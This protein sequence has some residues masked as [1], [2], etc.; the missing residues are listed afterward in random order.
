MARPKSPILG[1]PSAVSQTLPGFR[2]R[3]TRP[4][5]WAKA[6][7]LVIPI[8]SSST[9]ADRQLALGGLVEQALEVA[10]GHEL[11]DEVGLAR[12][13]A[14]VEHG[15]D[16]GV[17]AEAAHRLGLAQDARPAGRVEALG[18]DQREGHLAVEERVAGEVDPLLAALAQ[19]AQELV[20]AVG[21]RGGAASAV[22]GSG[23]RSAASGAPHS[24]QKAPSLFPAPHFGAVQHNLTLLRHPHERGS[25]WTPR[26]VP[27]SRLIYRRGLRIRSRWRLD[28]PPGAE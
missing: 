1:V 28:A 25:A 13:L 9:C 12:L 2:S 24:L 17:G 4:L 14:E 20:A 10:A 19:Q 11:R 3:W 26:T 8:A 22:V 16:V 15:D 7:P 27:S 5:A 18:L 23:A 6:S 21:D